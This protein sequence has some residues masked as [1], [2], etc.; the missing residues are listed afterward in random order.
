MGDAPRS[1]IV[2]PRVV[3]FDIGHTL[4]TGGDLS[5]R[6]LLAER[7]GLSE[8]ESRRVGRRIMIDPAVREQDVSPE[9]SRLLPRIDP[10]AIAEHL[11]A[12]WREQEDSVREVPGATHLVQSLKSLGFKVGVISNTWH[13]FY[14]G[15]LHRCPELAACLDFRIVSYQSGCK[16]PSTAIFRR[17]LHSAGE[18]PSSCL[19]IGDSYELDVEPALKVGMRAL[20]LLCRPEKEISLL[21]QVLRGEKSPPDGAVESLD[22]VLP[23]IV[24]GLRRGSHD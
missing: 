24:G 9:I 23:Y 7:L 20:W 6:A 19:M 1:G 3:F 2:P 5:A 22:E 18:P 4:A 15:F 12:V 11:S 10:A 14:H 17:A 8:K 21:A 13:P 16:K